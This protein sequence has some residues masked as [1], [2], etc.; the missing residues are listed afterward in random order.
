MTWFK[1]GKEVTN[2]GTTITYTLAGAVDITVESRK[3][4][5]P[6]ANGIGTW[7]H[8]T[9]CVLSNGKVLVLK[10]SLRDAKEYAEDYVIK[11]NMRPKEGTA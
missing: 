9:Y 8:T 6:H 10:S 2:E 7:D 1:S 4:H 3:R 11:R 5:I